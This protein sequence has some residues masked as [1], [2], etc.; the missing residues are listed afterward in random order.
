MK[1]CG[2]RAPRLLGAAML[3]MTA[4]CAVHHEAG[5]VSA[6]VQQVGTI[7]SARPVGPNAGSP[8]ARDQVLAAIGAP[9]EIP[10]QPATEFII[11]L[12]DGNLL[13]VMQPGATSLHAGDRVR[14]LRERGTRL[15]PLATGA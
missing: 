2:L 1:R 6:R 3:L 9:S 8:G 4:G 7:L 10:S 14:I 11:R 5:R 15:E 13:S 12:A